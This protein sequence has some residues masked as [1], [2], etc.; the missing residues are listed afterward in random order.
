MPVL[1]TI[2]VQIILKI[3]VFDTRAEH[4]YE[5]NKT[6]APDTAAFPVWLTTPREDILK[7]TLEKTGKEGDI[8]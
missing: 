5:L 4:E 7:D 2:P 6:Y 1:Q 8:K 3:P